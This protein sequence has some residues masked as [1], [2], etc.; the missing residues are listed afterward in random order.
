MYTWVIYDIRKNKIRAKVA[1]KC[2][3]LGLKRVQKS[4]FLGK[5][6]KTQLTAFQQDAHQLINLNTDVLFIVPM[7]KGAYQRMIQLGQGFDKKWLSKIRYV[8]FV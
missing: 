4:V 3:Q 8:H 6:T 2:K 1:K 7:T 5:A